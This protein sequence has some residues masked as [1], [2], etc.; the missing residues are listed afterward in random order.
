MLRVYRALIRSKLDYGCAVYDSARESYKKTLNTIHNTGIR[1]ATGALRTSR[2]ESLYSESSEPPLCLRRQY[3][4]ASYASKILCMRRH[5]TFQPLYNPRFQAIYDARP[6]A[7][8]PAGIR[9]SR[10][11][12]DA[13]FQQP[14]VYP[15]GVS[16]TAPWVTGRP[17][18]LTGLASNSKNT[19]SPLVYRQRFAKICSEFADFILIFTDGSKDT[20]AV[21]SAFISGTDVTYG[22]KLNDKCTILTAELYA[23]LNALKYIESSRHE[24][25]FLICTDSLSSLQAIDTLYSPHT[26]VQ[27]ILSLLA[28]L[29]SRDVTVVF[30]WVP[31]H[32]GIQGNELADTAAKAATEKDVFDNDRLPFNDL[33]VFFKSLFKKKF[34]NMW[35]LETNNKLKEIKPTVVPWGS[36]IRSTRRE[37]VVL[38]RLRI[39]HTL[40]T[41]S[42][43]FS[44][45]KI[46]PRCDTCNEALTVRHILLECSKYRGV[47][48]RLS[49]ENNISKVL[50]DDSKQIDKLFKFLRAIDLLRII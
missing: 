11:L 15:H 36:S 49:L 23:L 22:F 48:R 46:P 32:V 6:S 50:G 31:G 40:V 8:L 29:A 9:L 7:T 33:K 4:L 2:V 35:D 17:T 21:G 20:N 3:L 47:R 43:L 30:C 1:L 18:C 34:Q 26:L 16:A 25:A 42:Y 44:L 38:T 5:P 28:S 14:R 19:T 37:E 24:K 27:E 41:H 12:V 39:G 10:M 13:A 45:D